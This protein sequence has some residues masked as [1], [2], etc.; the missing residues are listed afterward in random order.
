MK[1][2]QYIP[3]D[4]FCSD[5]QLLGEPISKAWSTFFAAVEGMPL[6]EESIEVFRQCTGR[7]SYEPRVHAESLAICGRRS[8]KTSSF[9]KYL[10]WKIAT[11]D[12]AGKSS[13]RELLR[14]PII[15]QDMRVAKDIKAT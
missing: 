8:E 2:N 9:L 6:D 12:F 10:L 1:K 11:S 13:R 5:P 3:L 4:E 7:D 14:V 15:A